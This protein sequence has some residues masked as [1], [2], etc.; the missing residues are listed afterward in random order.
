[1]ATW[2]R[3]AAAG[4][5]VGFGAGVVAASPQIA[6]VNSTGDEY[7]VFCGSCH[8]PE[9]KGDGPAAK[10]LRKR[11]ADLTQLAKR[12]EGTYPADRAF[13]V[14]D[15]R[16]PVNGHGGPDMPAWGPI[17]SQS[18]ESQTPEDVKARIDALVRYVETL[19]EKP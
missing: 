2:A 6:Q 8:G 4:W 18:R 3:M 14:I 7:R 17:F 11:P 10:S 19:Q 5:I 13:K 12:N 15:G 16:V 9:G 1:M